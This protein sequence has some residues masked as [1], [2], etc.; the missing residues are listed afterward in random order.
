M[1]TL[2]DSSFWQSKRVLIT[3]HSGFKGWWLSRWLTLL[4]AQVYGIS[5][6][7]SSEYL[8]R[9]FL[10]E[11]DFFKKILLTDICEKSK[12]KE[13]VL[14]VDPEIV[15][16]LA[17]QPSVLEG[18][19][20]P[21]QT[22]ETNFLGTASLILIVTESVP[23]T[24]VI[25]IT[26]D[27]VY[28]NE[29]TN[30]PFIESD[31][32][33]INGDPYSA[34][35]A[36]ADFFASNYYPPNFHDQ[37]NGKILIARAGNVIGGGDWLPDRLIPDCVKALYLERD[38]ILRS[39]GSTRPWQNILDVIHGYILLAQSA[40]NQDV[41]SHS[42]FNFGP[43]ENGLIDS[44]TLCDLFFK[45]FEDKPNIIITDP[46]FQEHTRLN[47]CSQ[48]ANEILNWKPR[49]NIHESLKLTADWYKATLS[50]ESA[51]KISTNQINWYMLQ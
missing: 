44:Q 46:T 50:G 24:D 13:F 28:K 26:T 22:M 4:G 39:P 38:L 34:S 36:M 14:D 41:P 42:A 6:Q 32:L 45:N 2:I 11:E 20:A 8:H 1:T 40:K 43:A 10:L 18:Y 19:R 49:L 29:S 15:F 5:N 25:V 51:K 37:L 35:K 21:R 47:L 30:V 31:E 17:A 12:I 48:K 23:K 9:P 33:A 27:K 7:A 16:H 3:G